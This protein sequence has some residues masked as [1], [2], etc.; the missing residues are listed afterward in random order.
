MAQA[1]SLGWA[2]AAA[3]VAGLAAGQRVWRVPQ[4]RELGAGPGM[5]GDALDCLCWPISHNAGP[6]SGEAGGEV[7]VQP[8][9]PLRKEP[10]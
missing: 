8:N 9:N 7:L 6:M 4:C 3:R 1:N 10:R 2:C 5:L